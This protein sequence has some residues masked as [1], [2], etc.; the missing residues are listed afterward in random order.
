MHSEKNNKTLL[1]FNDKETY[2]KHRFGQETRFHREQLGYSQEK[3]GQMI[4]MT[5]QHLS[6]IEKGQAM[7]NGF[8]SYMI[9]KTLCFSYLD[10]LHSSMTDYVELSD[11]K[12]KLINII[13]TYDISENLCEH[14][15]AIIKET[16]MIKVDL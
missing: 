14:L 16:S 10:I 11:H 3:L 12:I 9:Q 6:K 7:I 2:F 15:G 13:L 5:K 8:D 4:G 1:N